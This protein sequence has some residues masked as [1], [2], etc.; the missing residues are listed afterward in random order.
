MGLSIHNKNVGQGFNGADKGA[1]MLQIL[2]VEAPGSNTDQLT[3]YSQ[4]EIP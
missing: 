4:C 1:I 3:R 2:F